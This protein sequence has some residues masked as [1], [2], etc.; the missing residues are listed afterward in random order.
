MRLFLVYILH[1]VLHTALQQPS[2]LVDG[3]GRY[4]V[5]VLHG[6]KVRQREAKL[7][8]PVRGHALFLHGPEQRLVAY[9]WQTPL[10][11]KTSIKTMYEF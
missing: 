10:S 7:S 9:H 1:H 3:V 4:V 6:V 5:A 2:E 8:Q 11:Y